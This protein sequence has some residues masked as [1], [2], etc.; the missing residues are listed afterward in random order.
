MIGLNDVEYQ[1]DAP[2]DEGAPL[3]WLDVPEHVLAFSRGAHFVCLT[4]FGAEPFPLPAGAEL[5]LAS[6]ELEGDAVAVDTTVWLRQTD[7]KSSE[8][9][10]KEGR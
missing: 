8:E 9:E 7:T 3:A 6:S 4:N 5:L 1:F 10:G 2:W